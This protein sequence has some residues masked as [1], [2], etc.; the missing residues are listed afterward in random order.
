MRGAKFEMFNLNFSIIF[1]FTFAVCLKR[2]TKTFHDLGIISRLLQRQFIHLP[3]KILALSKTFVV[4][5][6]S[7]AKVMKSFSEMVENIE[8]K[9]EN[10]GHPQFSIFNTN[11]V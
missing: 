3:G 8:G 5:N 10:A 6:S 2:Q 9:G 1:V 4:D 7:L 11:L